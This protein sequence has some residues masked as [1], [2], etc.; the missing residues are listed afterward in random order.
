MAHKKNAG[1][2]SKNVVTDS[3]T[4]AGDALEN[5]KL[6]LSLIFNNLN[7]MRDKS[8]ASGIFYTFQDLCGEE[9]WELLSEKEQLM[10]FACMGYLIE[11]DELPLVC[12]GILA[13]GEAIYCLK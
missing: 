8:Y 4:A 9:Y 7:K 2:E 5:S 10:S 11:H 13:N 6:P 12:P 3:T 1:I